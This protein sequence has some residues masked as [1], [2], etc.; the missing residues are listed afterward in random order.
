MIAQNTSGPT[1]AAYN[2]YGN[3]SGTFLD[4]FLQGLYDQNG[5][6]KMAAF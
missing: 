2:V 4:G 1:Q 6:W 5:Y 3:S